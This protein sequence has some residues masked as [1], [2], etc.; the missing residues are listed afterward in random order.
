M[1]D[2]AHIHRQFLGLSSPA[3]HTAADWLVDDFAGA[4]AD[5]GQALVVVP[6]SRAQRRLLELLAQRS[7]GRALVPPTIVTLGGLADRLLPADQAPIASGLDTL[8]VWASVLREAKL[9]VLSQVVPRAP[10]RDD[11]PGWWALAEQVTQAAD[12]L[13]AQLLQ[14]VDVPKQTA[15][16]ND[17]PRWEVLAE[18]GRR[19]HALLADRGLMDLHAAR[20]DAIDSAGC[21][22]DGPIVLI[23]TADLQP[24]HQRMLACVSAPV[25]TL[26]FA[27]ER[28][29]EGF[30]EFGRLIESYWVE[31][32]LAI[33]NACLGFVD[34]PSDQARAVVQAVGDWADGESLS[35]DEITVGLGDGSLAGAVE[36]ALELADLPARSALGQRMGRSRPV[37][38]LRALAEFAE[39]LRFDKLASFLRH[40]DAE[41]YVARVADA[42]PGSWLTLL[43]RYATDHLAARPTGGWLG[44]PDR[45]QAMD[46]VYHA[47]LSLLPESVNTLR[48]LTRWAEAI[49]AA[50][51]EVYGA[52]RL[53]RYTDKDR[54]AVAALET[55][56][57]VLD[58]IAS[59]DEGSAPHCTF[60]QAVG[61]VVN[62]LAGQLIPEPGGPPAIELVGFL[63]LLLD[64]APRL[65]L[66]GMNEH[67]VP[68]PPRTSGLLPEGVRRELGL[69]GDQHRLARDGYA[70]S[71]MIA[72]RQHHHVRLIAGRRS[73]EGDPLVP[74]RL[75][76]RTDD[77]SLVLRVSEF[78]ENQGD[79]TVLPPT[80]LTAGKQDRFLIPRPVIPDDPITSLRV[81]AFRDYLACPYRFYLKHVLKLEP[82]D[83]H[84]VELS[85]SK[86]GTLTHEALRVLAG[87]DMR[88]VSDPA[89]ISERLGMALDR[90]FRKV[91]GGAPTIAARVQA[92]QIRYRLEAF[93]PLHAEMIREGWQIADQEQRLSATVHVDGEPF[94][95]T[96][97][98]DRIDRHDDGRYR[99]I[100]YK[101]SDTAKRPD[102]TH[103]KTI[104]GVRS[105]VDLQL[106]LYL[107]LSA[108]QGVDASAEL[109]YINLPKK[110]AETAFQAADWTRDELK[111]ARKQRDDVI[112]QV[113]A[114]I[115]WPP[116]QPP[117]FADGLGGVCADTAPDRA[118]LIRISSAIAQELSDA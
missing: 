55:I 81:T 27:E 63:E 64:D 118:G 46:A 8:L 107:D 94:T 41:E 109:G 14:V 45:V 73:L 28:D 83:D 90:A 19:Y 39:G 59:I 66:T 78:V 80:M 40:P 62:R 79:S 54:P 43:D 96:G 112:R 71:S 26:V 16:F 7:V 60:A 56:G 116:K 91:Y 115:F 75:L 11:W 21:Q 58:Q 42:S 85:A 47:A 31:R 98:V 6:G 72:S 34:R 33:D 89:S 52:R 25:Y 101:T 70:L 103:R 88:A 12:E 93:A 18:L 51:A 3:L 9:E 30:N 74:S 2:S 13:G 76:L 61:L 24:V 38:L 32:S 69:P 23:A 48:P 67:H 114:G 77:E 20:C 5:L 57:A 65:I 10:G 82:L 68:Q 29:A 17:A 1:P 117:I 36:R 15:H 102:Q 95:I 35:A 108:D 100:D 37:L 87:G 84:A 105:W 86:F 92:E 111:T 22:H 50:L 49:A 113:R 106:P 53:N 110:V 4:S 104:D 99:L 44:D 97:Q